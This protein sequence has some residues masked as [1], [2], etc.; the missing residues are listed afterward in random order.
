M[1]WSFVRSDMAFCS[2]FVM[3]RLTFKVLVDFFRWLNRI[4]PKELLCLG[5]GQCLIYILTRDSS[6]YSIKRALLINS[7]MSLFN[8]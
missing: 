1:V 2:V 8:S 7:E 3:F 6:K 5:E 4:Y